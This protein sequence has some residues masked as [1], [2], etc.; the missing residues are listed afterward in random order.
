MQAFDQ[1]LQPTPLIA[2]SPSPGQALV[3]ACAATGQDIKLAVL[4]DEFYPRLRGGRL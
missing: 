2:C 3:T 4:F 1:L